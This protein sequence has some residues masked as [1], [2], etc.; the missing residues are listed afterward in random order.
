ML[1]ISAPLRNPA[2][3]CRPSKSHIS[4]ISFSSARIG[5]NCWHL[6]RP[7]PIDFQN[8]LPEVPTDFIS[9]QNQGVQSRLLLLPRFRQNCV[10]QTCISFCLPTAHLDGFFLSFLSMKEKILL[11]SYQFCSS[12]SL[13]NRTYRLLPTFLLLQTSRTQTILLK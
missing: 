13:L 11:K 9:W 5:Q 6:C 12:L 7:R 3:S 2:S 4:R 1:E 10:G 8:L